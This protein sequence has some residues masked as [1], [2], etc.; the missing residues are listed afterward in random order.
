M[1]LDHAHD[2][3]RAAPAPACAPSP[4]RFAAERAPAGF[5]ELRARR[6]L[7][8]SASAAPASRGHVRAAID[9]AVELALAM[10][11]ALPPS[12]DA[13]AAI[14][15]VIAD[16]AFRALALGAA[17]LAVAVPSLSAAADG[18][19]LGVED[20]AA[21]AAWIEAARSAPIALWLQD[22]D[23]SLRVLAPVPLAQ[24]A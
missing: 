8:V 20:S 13:G 14:E 21:I 23:R 3:H 12:V 15:E 4:V 16:Q 10:R 19:A 11:G 5:E 24:L 17:G 18:G 22:E 7:C 9:E 6:F 2:E 1:R